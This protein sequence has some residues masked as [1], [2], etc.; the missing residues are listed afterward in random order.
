MLMMI[1]LGVSGPEIKSP[2][3][4]MSLQSRKMFAE[5]AIPSKHSGG[6]HG[7]TDWAAK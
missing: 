4:S 6:V 1:L 3:V 7:R 5:S 2:H